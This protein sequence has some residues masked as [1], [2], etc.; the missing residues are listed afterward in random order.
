[1]EELN[2]NKILS[3]EDKVSNIKD[4]LQQFELN[5][6]NILFKAL[7]ESSWAIPGNPV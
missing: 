5:K 1:M 4:I 3:R 6:N 2:V 7:F